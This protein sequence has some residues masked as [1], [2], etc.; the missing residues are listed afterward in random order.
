MVEV[1]FLFH[2]NMKYSKTKNSE[3]CEILSLDSITLTIMVKV[4]F[5][6]FEMLFFNYFTIWF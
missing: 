2:T 1:E 3:G 5:I 6:L 4:I